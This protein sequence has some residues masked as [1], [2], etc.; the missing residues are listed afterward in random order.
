MNSFSEEVPPADWV[1]EAEAQ[2]T[3]AKPWHTDATSLRPELPLTPGSPP[4][5]G[6]Q[7]VICWGK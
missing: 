5:P 2:D 1:M 3:P 7:G 4:L 6:A